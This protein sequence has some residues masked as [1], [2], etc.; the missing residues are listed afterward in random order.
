[1]IVNNLSTILGKKRITKAELSRMIGIRYETIHRI[2]HDKT[3][4]ID[5]N[6]L[7]KLCWAL[8][9]TPSEIFEYVEAEQEQ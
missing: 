5:F 4:G 1:M 7:D 6:T 8:Q 3:K 2:Y 9:C